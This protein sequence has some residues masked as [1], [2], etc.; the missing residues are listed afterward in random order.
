[1]RFD[2][3][4]MF[5]YDYMD[6]IT[7]SNHVNAIFMGQLLNNRLILV[8]NTSQSFTLE[9]S[10][11]L[12]TTVICHT[13][14]Q[15]CSYGYGTSANNSILHPS[16]PPY[17]VL[18][19]CHET[20]VHVVLMQH[21]LSL[22]F[23]CFHYQHYSLCPYMDGYEAINVVNTCHQS[24]H[25]SWMP[26]W[27][28]SESSCQHMQ[29]QQCIASIEDP[30]VEPLLWLMIRYLLLFCYLMKCIIP[31]KQQHENGNCCKP[32]ASPACLNML[33]TLDSAWH[34]ILHMAHDGLS[35]P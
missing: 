20:V 2:S 24:G 23:A 33:M 26:V 9:Q 21:Q 6:C 17:S 12:S 13:T 11:K 1:M 35:I 7:S 31:S 28:L 32:S 3:C 4:S 29:L 30:T 14:M 5:S 22:L 8:S 27:P 15:A 10:I 18:H 25:G 34:V 16:M 19:S